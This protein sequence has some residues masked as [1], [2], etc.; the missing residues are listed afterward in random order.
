MILANYNPQN[1]TKLC[2][3]F[4]VKP[5]NFFLQKFE[6]DIMSFSSQCNVEAASHP[7]L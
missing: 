5:G 3:K 1:C 2:R 6:N 4:F 7:G